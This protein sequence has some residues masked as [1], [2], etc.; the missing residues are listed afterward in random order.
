MNK[1]LL[2]GARALS[3]IFRP[4]Y[5]PL[6]GFVALFLFTYLSLL[7]WSFKAL[8]LLI[9]LLGTLLL[10]RLTIRFW[11]Q[12]NGLKLHHLRLREHRFF[13]YLIFLLFYHC[14]RDIKKLEAE[15]A[16]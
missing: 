8:I 10:P 7:P 15:K 12:T 9:V 11:R 14:E 16:M 3:S 5:F 2:L 4:Q 13:P 6:V 1:T